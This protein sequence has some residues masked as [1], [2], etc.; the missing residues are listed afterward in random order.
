M[1]TVFTNIVEPLVVSGTVGGVI[2]FGVVQVLRAQTATLTRR[3]DDTAAHLQAVKDA[4]TRLNAAV[5][6]NGSAQGIVNDLS[7]LHIKVDATHDLV[8]QIQARCPVQQARDDC[9]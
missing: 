4:V 8:I 3:F 1:T 5:G 9:T 2:M 6:L 7:A